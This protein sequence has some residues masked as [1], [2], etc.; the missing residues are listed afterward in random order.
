[1]PHIST[2]QFEQ[3]KKLYLTGNY[4]LP[5][6][7]RMFDISKEALCKKLKKDSI[8]IKNKIERS[9]RY[10]PNN[11]YFENID[12]E[13]K[14]YFLGLLY[15]DGYI[16]EKSNSVFLSLQEKDKSV[17]ETL[18]RFIQDRPLIHV[19]RKNSNSQNMYRIMIYGEKIVNDLKQHG[20]YQRK[21]HN[22]KFP[23][24]VPEDLIHHFI[25]GNMDGD[26][27]ISKSLK[28]PNVQFTGSRDYIRG[29]KDFLEGNLDIHLCTFTAHRC[30]N[31]I[32]SGQINGGKNVRKFLSWI[33]K[34]ATVFLER[35]HIKY[36]ALVDYY[37]EFSKTRLC[38]IEECTN[39]HCAKGYC[40]HHYDMI[41]KNNKR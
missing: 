31:T 20:C 30:E 19:K 28:L 22:L 21:S 5:E 8:P 32:L 9:R 25:R 15:A 3:V 2:E 6:L 18:N 4:N 10:Y 33:Y 40:K 1:M 34:D 37:N 17:L 7:G 35:K 23:T 12:T 14:A 13:D 29:F 27:C 41:I 11:D 39:K 36:L 16:H 24:T 38:E 26:G